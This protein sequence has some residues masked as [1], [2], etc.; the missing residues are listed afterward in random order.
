MSVGVPALDEI[1]ERARLFFV[2]CWDGQID[3]QTADRGIKTCQIDLIK[4]KMAARAGRVVGVVQ[5]ENER[6]RARVQ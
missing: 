5:L 3:S 4:Y 2:A 1:G 6:A